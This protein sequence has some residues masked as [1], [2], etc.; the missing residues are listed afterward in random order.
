MPKKFFAAISG[1][2]MRRHFVPA[3]RLRFLYQ[4]ARRANCSAAFK[5]AAAIVILSVILIQSA[6]S[7]TVYPKYLDGDRNYILFDG[8][9]GVGRY[10]VRDSLKVKVDAPPAYVI[11]VDWV[12][13]NDADRNSTA[14]S[15]GKMH[16]VLAFNTD[17]RQ[18]FTLVK[19]KLNPLKRDA[20]R[21]EGEALVRLAEIVFCLT[22]GEKFYGDLS[23]EFYPD[24]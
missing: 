2:E 14:I 19:G 18:L 5:A 13:V 10:L 24:L 3:R 23:D 22:T 12:S 6:A 21:A 20:T 9:Q 1:L 17:T 8:F 7:A 16:T 15:P 11:A 4:T